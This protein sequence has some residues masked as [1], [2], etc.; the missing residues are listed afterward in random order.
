[1]HERKLI[2]L[3]AAILHEP[4]YGSSVEFAVEEARRIFLSAG[5]LT[6]QEISVMKDSVELARG[7]EPIPHSDK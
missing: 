3:M 7:K 1:M 2:A 4:Q 5:R 6:D